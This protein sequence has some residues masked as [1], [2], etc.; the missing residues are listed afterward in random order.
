MTE[1]KNPE[2]SLE[3]YR[4]LTIDQLNDTYKEIIKALQAIGEGT[5]EDIAAHL[6]CDKSKIWKRMSELE[7]MEVVYKPGNKRVLKSGR[8]GFTYMLTSQNT[9]RTQASDKL[10]SG[11]SVSDYSKTITAIQKNL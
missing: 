8:S 6:K 1:R 3:A 11:K 10:L 9:Q 5:F 4:S 2:T 7:R